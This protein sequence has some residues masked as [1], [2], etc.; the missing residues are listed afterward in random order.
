MAFSRNLRL[1]AWS[2]PF[3]R[4]SKG[5]TLIEL[6]VVIAIIAILAAIL[7]PVFSR[8][9]MRA[10]VAKCT[11]NMAQLAKAMVMYANDNK[12]YL[13]TP[14]WSGDWP[15]WAGCKPPQATAQM[16]KANWVYPEAGQIWP[17]VKAARVYLC[18]QDVK[19]AANPD[20]WD[21]PAGKS[22]K[23]MPLSYSMNGRFSTGNPDGSGAT[24]MDSVRGNI[25]PAQI[26][27]LIQEARNREDTSPVVWSAGM[28]DSV[29][30]AHPGNLQDN[31]NHVHYDGTCVAYLDGH[32]KWK[33]YKQLD[34][35][36]RNGQWMP[37]SR[38]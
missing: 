24:P 9:R 13:P 38:Y 19:R 25:D 30:D 5:F 37:Y 31:P 32:A 15:N 12:G 33:P 20:Y 34:T 10:N 3:R 2:A 18:P 29:F 21:P 28:N 8:V 6:L 1:Y 22:I 26:M 36:H 16:P 35:E 14:G 23:D 7:F 11:S 27:L 17:Y 4:S